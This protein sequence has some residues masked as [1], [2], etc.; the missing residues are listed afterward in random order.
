[1]AYKQSVEERIRHLRYL[2][3]IHRVIYYIFDESV[4][5]DAQYTNLENE[6]KK[7]VTE[8]P[9]LE[10]TIIY[11]DICPSRNLGSSN[12]KDYPGKIV[13]KALWMM[14][15]TGKAARG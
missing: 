13:D 10:K 4:I 9:E 12:V 8:N 6:L 1:M 3:L 2:C 15:I 11:A 7:L 14:R 5:D